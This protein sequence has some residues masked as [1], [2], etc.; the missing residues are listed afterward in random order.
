MLCGVGEVASRMNSPGYRRRSWPKT[1][2]SPCEQSLLE[3]DNFAT[4]ANDVVQDD[5]LPVDAV[6]KA[7]AE[8][9]EYL[10]CKGP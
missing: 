3:R 9:I 4:S 5:L 8:V 6:N 1:P 2:K 10:V 7:Q